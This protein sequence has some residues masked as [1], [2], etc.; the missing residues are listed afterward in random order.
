MLD[1]STPLIGKDMEESQTNQALAWN[2]DNNLIEN[3]ATEFEAGVSKPE[4]EIFQL[5][6]KTVGSV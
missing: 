3:V 4:G 5:L 1:I 2:S 6:Y